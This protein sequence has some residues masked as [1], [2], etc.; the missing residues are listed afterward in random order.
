MTPGRSAHVV[1]HIWM[2][3]A[4]TVMGWAVKRKR[5]MANPFQGTTVAV[6]RAKPKLREREFHEEEWRTILRA[7]LQPSPPRM[8]PYNAAARRW[9]PW[10][11]AYTGSRPGEACQLRAEDIQRHPKGFWVINITP[12]AGTVKGG[13]ARVVP[14]HE[15]LVE[16]GFVAFAQS[17][18]NGPLFFDPAG[19]RKVDD[20]PT[21][22]VRQPWA[23]AR[24]KLSEWVRALGVTDPGISPNHAWRHTYKRRAARAGLERRI[25]FA[26]CGHVS[27]D[28]GDRYETPSVEDM[29]VEGRKFPRYD[30][31]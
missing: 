31:G 3:S 27:G 30:V 18:G 26:M 14:L 29:A 1:E 13:A 19:R 23:K 22:P 20:D 15:H 16:Q 9:V 17:K 11:C 25:R 24:D 4:K 2:R 10:L 6:P 8:E 28:E 12:E 7:T 5:L 21:N